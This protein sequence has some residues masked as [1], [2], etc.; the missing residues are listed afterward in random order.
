MALNTMVTAPTTVKSVKL[1]FLKPC[2]ALL[3]QDF[4]IYAGA[5]VPSTKYSAWLYPGFADIVAPHLFPT[6]RLSHVFSLLSFRGL[7]TAPVVPAHSAMATAKG[8]RHYD[9]D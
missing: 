2:G 3:V 8:A 5:A 1:P 4:V 7:V 6:S 9:T